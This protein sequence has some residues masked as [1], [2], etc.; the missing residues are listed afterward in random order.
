MADPTGIKAATPSMRKR[1]WM[2]STNLLV[3]IVAAVALVGMVNWLV[4]RHYVRFDWTKTSYYALS[5]KT[6]QVI[7]NLSAPI[8]IIVFLQP[9][10]AREYLEK[11]YQDTRDLL[12]EF[13]YIGK[14]RVVV[15]YV[16]PD[17]DMARAEQLARQ[18]KVDVANVVIFVSGD[19]H[20][21]VTL[22]EMVDFDTQEMRGMS[23]DP[24]QGFRVKAYKGEGAF[25]A[26]I[27]SVTEGVPPKVYFLTGHGE[28]DPSSF[29]TERGYSTIAS[30]I[31]RDNILV[32]KW[33]LLAKQ[34]LPTDAGLIVIA[35]PRTTFLKSERD[36]LQNYLRNQGR[37]L[38]LLEPFEKS[39]LEPFLAEWGVEVDNNL[40]IAR[41]G[42]LFGA[43]IMI[44][45]APGVEY[46]PHPITAKLQ[47][48]NTSFPYARSVRR[49]ER[50]P[51]S[52]PDG[53]RVTE[54]VNTPPEYWGET[55]P[56][57]EHSKFD[58]AED[59]RGPL[60]VAVAVETSEPRGVDLKL[61]VTRLVVIGSTG[62]IDNST[63]SSV[64]GNLDFTMNALNWLLQR[65][66]LMAIA[67]KLPQEFSLDMTPQQIR[68]IY[69][70]TMGGLPLAVAIV[71]TI[72][73]LRRRK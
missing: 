71:G 27:Q 48:I 73:W 58:A 8:K 39:D 72:V 5:D 1:R 18:Y 23:A 45:D 28:R 14:D 25:L 61:G 13:Q 16:D 64:P 66:Q 62:F 20:K 29:D 17:R 43:E 11:V 35:G 65:E 70:L 30:Y 21:Y 24:N 26:A 7:E 3:Q 44:I 2:I 6:K 22:E 50:P 34:E 32:E 51:G 15:E 56:D 59:R 57:T 36:L 55:N 60:P 19:R 54:L 37:L 10:A 69:L 67:P 42:T 9:N 52:G 68:T 31:K 4:W 47:G 12:K 40:A 41:G 53:P 46:G 63:I 49:A 38:V 33:N